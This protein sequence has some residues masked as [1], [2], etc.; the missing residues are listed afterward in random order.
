MI[1]KTIS[2]TSCSSNRSQRKDMMLVSFHCYYA[3]IEFILFSEIMLL[4]SESKLSPLAGVFVCSN[5]F[6]L[7][8]N[9]EIIGLNNDN[10]VVY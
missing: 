10:F 4:T 9:N 3:M 1:E 7:P 5:L 8:L 2:P 6:L